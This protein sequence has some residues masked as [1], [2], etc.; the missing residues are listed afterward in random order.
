MIIQFDDFLNDTFFGD[1]WTNNSIQL[2]QP[3]I[4][5][6]NAGVSEEV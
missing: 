1:Q 3:N 5:G 6:R 4:S 2:I